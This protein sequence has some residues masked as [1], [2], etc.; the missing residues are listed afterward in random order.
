MDT[1]DKLDMII[2]LNESLA[3]RGNTMAIKPN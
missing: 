2:F 3:I 1:L